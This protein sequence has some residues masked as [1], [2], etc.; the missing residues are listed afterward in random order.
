MG[1]QVALLAG[2]VVDENHGFGS[3]IFWEQEGTE[4]LGPRRVD[5][6]VGEMKCTLA[7]SALL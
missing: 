7:M 4:L 6:L 5:D 2:S 3:L 1:V